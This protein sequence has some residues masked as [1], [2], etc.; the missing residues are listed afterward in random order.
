MQNPMVVLGEKL[1]DLKQMVT[2]LGEFSGLGFD[3]AVDVAKGDGASP[4]FVVHLHLAFQIG[5]PDARIDTGIGK[6]YGRFDLDG[7]FEAAPGGNDRATLKLLFQGDV[8]QGILPPLLYAG[9]CSGSGSRCARV[10]TL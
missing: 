6:F 8:Q 3:I 10:A 7:A 5:S 4:S 2:A 9:G 1:R